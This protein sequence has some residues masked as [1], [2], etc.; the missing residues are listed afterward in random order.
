M[1]FP[2]GEYVIRHWDEKKI[3]LI[4]KLAVLGLSNIT[5]SE[6]L[7]IDPE[8]FRYWIEHHEGVKEA[9]ME[10]RTAVGCRIA[11]AFIKKATGYEAEEEVA[12]YDR[13]RHEWVKTT[14]KKHYPADSWAAAR[15]L[16]LHFD[17]WSVTRKIQIN[18]TNTNIN[19]DFT[20][21]TDEQ[22]SLLEEIGLKQLNAHTDENQTAS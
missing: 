4:F 11:E 15:Y 6:C 10:G 18:Q 21:M 16:E 13:G 8:T 20:G 14:V 19:I 22:L 9:L 5:I 1:G 3:P 2:K 17:Q 12:T 7:E